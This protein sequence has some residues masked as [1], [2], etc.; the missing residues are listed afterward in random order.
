MM[1]SRYVLALAAVSAAGGCMVG[2]D[3]ERPPP[4][5]PP[6]LAFKETTGR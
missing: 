2:P 5:D 3:Y 1:S 6:S 4:A